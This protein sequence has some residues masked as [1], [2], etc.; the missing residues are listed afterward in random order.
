[1]NLGLPEILILFFLLVIPLA[2]VVFPAWRLIARTGH[3]GELGVL[4]VVPLV[5][6]ALLWYLAFAEWPALEQADTP[7]NEPRG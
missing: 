4:A 5:N 6:I 1:M 3:R 7:T 2:L